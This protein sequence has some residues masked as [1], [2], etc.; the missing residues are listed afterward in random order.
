MNRQQ[1]FLLLVIAVS[2][3]LSLWVLLPLLEFVLLAIVFSYILHPLNR[4]IEPY[5][6]RKFSPILVITGA[7]IAI[8]LPILYIAQVLYR[9]LMLLLEGDV[10]LQ[11]GAIEARIEELSGVQVD[12]DELLQIFA[13][14]FVDIL[15]GDVPDLLSTIVF[16]GF[17]LA[18]ILF[19]VYYLLRDG[20]DFVDWL[21]TVTPL[22]HRVGNRLIE[23]IDRTTHGVIVGHL[24]VAF[25]EGIL[26]GIAFWFVGLPNP[27]FWAFVM[28]ILSILP[29]I[30][31][32]LVWAPAAGYLLFIDLIPE[33]IFLTAWGLFVIGLIDNY[34]RPILIDRGARLNPGIIL[35]GVFGGIYAIGISGLFIGPIVIGV[36]AAALTVFSS[37]WEQ[38]GANN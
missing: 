36:L 18:V 2:A 16:I 32:F 7:I 11:L 14:E 33:A 28:I 34:L 25:V 13:E 17:G 20:Q 5:T 4:R 24:L 12:I 35:I 38:L 15:F 29:V 22:E 26:G 21:L 3:V 8:I 27:V 1:G 10:Q 37:E 6:G 19:L 30:G 31:P 23:Q 9:D